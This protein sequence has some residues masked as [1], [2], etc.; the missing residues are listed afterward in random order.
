M[1]LVFISEFASL[2]EELQIQYNEMIEK[3]R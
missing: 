2:P 3:G 1:C